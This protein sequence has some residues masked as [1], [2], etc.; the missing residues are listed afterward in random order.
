MPRAIELR[1]G[2]GGREMKKIYFGREEEVKP[3]VV[4]TFEITV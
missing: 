1:S 2:S 4:T 3:R